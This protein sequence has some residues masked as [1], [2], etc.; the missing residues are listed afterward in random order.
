[1]ARQPGSDGGDAF[2][3]FKP[4]TFVG[5]DGGLQATNGNGRF[6]DDFNDDHHDVFVVIV[7]FHADGH[8]M[9]V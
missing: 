4:S 8:Q 9:S 3:W 6:V 1:L 2:R 7:D 5:N